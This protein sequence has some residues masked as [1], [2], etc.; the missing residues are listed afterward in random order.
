[1]PHDHVHGHHHHHHDHDHHHDHGHHHHG[2]GHNHAHG[3]HL[4]SHMHDED[5]AADLQ[6]LAA[7]FIDG[8]HA[9]TVAIEGERMSVDWTGTSPQVPGAPWR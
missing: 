9:V 7:Q 2:H 1:M 8:Q 4:H 5:A 6:V 3:E